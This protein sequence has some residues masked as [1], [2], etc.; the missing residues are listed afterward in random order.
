MT[1]EIA[2][3]RR[4]AALAHVN[5]DRVLVRPA[6][7]EGDVVLPENG[8]V[9]AYLIDAL[10]HGSSVTQIKT[11]T[12]WSKPTVMVNLYRVAKKSGVGIHRRNNVM[13]LVVPKGAE[14]VYPRKEVARTVN[15]GRADIN[16]SDRVRINAY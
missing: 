4:I 6:R 15:G 16:A 11:E 9:A 1:L 2:R 10:G 8:T 3:S 13:H 5:A 7:H 12:G 14:N